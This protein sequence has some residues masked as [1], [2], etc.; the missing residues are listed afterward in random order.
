MSRFYDFFRGLWRLIRTFPLSVI[1]GVII[2]FIFLIVYEKLSVFFAGILITV[3]IESLL[4]YSK[5]GYT[6]WQ[7]SHPLHK[8]LGPIASSEECYIYFSSFFRDLTKPQ[9]FKLLLPNPNRKDIKVEGPDFLIGEGDALTLAL[10]MSLL[11]KIRIK[12][13]KIVVERGDSVNKK[14]GVNCFCIGAHNIRTR[15]I[16][17]FFNNTYFIF[18]NNYTVIT[19]PN[20]KV[21]SE[22]KDGK[23]IKKGVYIIPQSDTEPIDFG[24]ILKLTN[25]FHTS[26][27]AFVVAGIGPAGTSGAAYFLLTHFEE[28]SK[29]GNEFGVLIQTP[30]GY[31]SAI[32]VDFDKVAQFYEVY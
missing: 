9:E 2:G 20:E 24:F 10:I 28:L 15:E 7:K 27:I 12:P 32:R 5:I 25:Q 8:L 14:W 21:V 6:E 16:L 31:Q 22:Q 19:R 26:K 13:E 1:L 23:C 29:L 18:D 4:K 11:S 30:C 3:V 17:E